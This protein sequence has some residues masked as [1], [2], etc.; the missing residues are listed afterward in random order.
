MLP[1]RGHAVVGRKGDD[2]LTPQQL[3]QRA[4]QRRASAKLLPPGKVRDA[5]LQEAHRDAAL[6]DSMREG[7]QDKL[8]K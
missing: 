2:K 3:E 7:K 4:A 5:V 6:A 8:D 1:L